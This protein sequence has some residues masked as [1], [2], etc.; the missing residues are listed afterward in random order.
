MSTDFDLTGQVA[1]ITGATGGFGSRIA[2]VLA[3]HGADI[4]LT[5]RRRNRLDRLA[6][7]LAVEE[8]CD[9]SANAVAYVPHDVT[10]D[11]GPLFNF[12]EHTF[13]RPVSIL[14]NNAGIGHADK[15]IDCPSLTFRNVIEVD[16]MAPFFYAQEAARRMR[17]AGH[18]GAIVNI[19]SIFGQTPGKSMV[20]YAVAKA[21]LIQ[22][23]KCLA[24]EWGS[25]GVR[26]NALAPGWC[27]TE[28]TQQYLQSERGASIMHDIPLGRFG[29]PADLDGAILLLASDAGRYLN[30]AVLT[31]D[32]GLSVGMR[33]GTRAASAKPKE[34][35]VA[36][37][38]LG[39]SVDY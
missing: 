29:E 30:G 4:V 31:I 38:E 7:E 25:S 34:P 14:I 24:L 10:D 28:M 22:L 21:G 33:E 3:A 11:P 27:L 23:T 8:L 15:A 32:G 26:V 18:G 1:L 13:G 39:I 17:K 16:L 19:A 6:Q 35:V 12:V 37:Q 20:A 5:G 36:P 9:D 2:H